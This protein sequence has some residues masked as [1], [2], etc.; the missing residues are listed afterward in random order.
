MRPRSVSRRSGAFVTCG[1]C[2]CCHF[3]LRTA[4]EFQDAGDATF[5]VIHGGPIGVHVPRFRGF[6]VFVIVAIRPAG[7]TTT[8]PVSDA[9]TAT[10]RIKGSVFGIS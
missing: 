9:V 5:H 6:A 1:G 8:R 3:D 10:I 4:D 2:S 7:A